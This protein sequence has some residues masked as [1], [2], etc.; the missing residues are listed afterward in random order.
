MALEAVSQTSQVPK[1][2]ENVAGGRGQRTERQEL[3][4]LVLSGNV[5]ISPASSRA[6]DSVDCGGQELLL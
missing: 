6:G 1:L 2:G 5:R 4:A 3:L